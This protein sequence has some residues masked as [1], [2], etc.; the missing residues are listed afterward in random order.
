MV[1]CF[2]KYLVRVLLDGD[3]RVYNRELR[4]SRTSWVVFVPVCLLQ[5]WTTFI[6]TRFSK[7]EYL[8]RPEEQSNVM[9]LIIKFKTQRVVNK[10]EYKL[11]VQTQLYLQGTISYKFRLYRLRVYILFIYTCT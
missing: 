4:N 10:E 9:F 7:P 6:S 3:L 2:F 1:I 5:G 8:T 11:T